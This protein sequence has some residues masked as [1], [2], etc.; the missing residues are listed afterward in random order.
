MRMPTASFTRIPKFELRWR[1][2]AAEIKVEVEIRS[3]PTS[4]LVNPISMDLTLPEALRIGLESKFRTVQNAREM[5]RADT[6]PDTE[7][8]RRFV[9][10]C[11]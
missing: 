5:L 2:T 4:E 7:R 9:Q 3:I 10:Y 6:S 1:D 8:Q 11:S